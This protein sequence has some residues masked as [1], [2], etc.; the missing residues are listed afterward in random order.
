M[1]LPGEAT[2]DEAIRAVKEQFTDAGFDCPDETARDIVQ[3][4]YNKQQK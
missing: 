4:A 1:P 3:K 2:D